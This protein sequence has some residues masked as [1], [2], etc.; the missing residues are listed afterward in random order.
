MSAIRLFRPEQESG[1][2]PQL[3]VK[4]VI[5]AYR[6]HCKADGVHADSTIVDRTY[7]LG[8][9]V[10]ECGHL[11]VADLKPF[12]LTDFVANHPEWRSVATRRNRSSAIRAA[13]QWATDQERIERNP[14]KRVVYAEAERREAM[15]DADLELIVTAANKPT[16]EVLRFVRLTGCRSTEACE[17]M[18]ADVSLDLGTWTI[19]K[20][21]TR[22][23]TGKAKKVALV[24]EAVDLL[25]KVLSRRKA[26]DNGP[27]FRNTL[28]RP[29]SRCNLW[30]A[31]QRFKTKVGSTTPASVHG[32]RHG[33]ATACVVAGAAP[34]LVAAQ[35]GNST[36]IC[37][38]YYVH[39]EDKL[40]AI[41]AAAQ[42]GVPK[43]DN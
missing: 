32:L 11:V 26:G 6:R 30:Q 33:F 2:S 27:I 38:R 40:D 25:R 7:V 13:F 17:A 8:L 12:H 21:K 35:M 18:P 28:G 22:R 43:K 31:L 36:R 23:R 10:A 41:R 15:P 34:A 20:H 42:L 24:P 3:T 14:F 9:F 5:E 19:P 29:W 37:E 1:G 16:E 39:L 4:D